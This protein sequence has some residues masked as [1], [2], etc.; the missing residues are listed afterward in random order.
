MNG[1]E[2]EINK[3]K[4]NQEESSTKKA[5]ANLLNT[6]TTGGKILVGGGLF[7]L[8]I[9]VFESLPENHKL[10]AAAAGL[11]AMLGGG[12]LLYWGANDIRTSITVKNKIN[13]KYS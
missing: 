4:E 3:K 6:A 10:S 12:S 1:M 9:Y 5:F 13:Q 2:R 8:G 11:T 7:Y